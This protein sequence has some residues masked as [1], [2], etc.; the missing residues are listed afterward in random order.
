MKRLENS[1][2]PAL[3]TYNPSQA[4]TP[5]AVLHFVSYCSM[6]D[7]AAFVQ[8]NT[9]CIMAVTGKTLS[10]DYCGCACEASLK[11]LVRLPCTLQVTSLAMEQAIQVVGSGSMSDN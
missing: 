2:G 3:R 9:V 7:V 4:I 5:A 6:Q 8:R 10:A 1:L 11:V